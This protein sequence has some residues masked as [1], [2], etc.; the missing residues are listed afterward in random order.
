MEKYGF[1][2]DKIQ[3]LIKQNDMTKELVQK[4]SKNIEEITLNQ[5]NIA[6]DIVRYRKHNPDKD[7]MCELC[8][9]IREI[10]EEI[11]RTFEKP[12]KI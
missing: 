8:K 1:D 12:H 4:F 10:K 5:V 2:V 9:T 7:C 3:K 11:K 6:L